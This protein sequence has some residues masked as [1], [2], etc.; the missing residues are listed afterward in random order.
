MH[1][2]TMS[3]TTLIVPV[4]ETKGYFL[5]ESLLRPF[6][7]RIGIFSIAH[8]LFYGHKWS[9]RR[10]RIGTA[11]RRDILGIR[12]RKSGSNRRRNWNGI[13]SHRSRRDR[14]QGSNFYTG[15]MELWGIF[16]RSRNLGKI[17]RTNR[18]DRRIATLGTVAQAVL[19][20]VKLNPQCSGLSL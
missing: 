18:R 17:R 15:S 20:V 5:V 9:A 16:R 7:H 14:T 13:R 19:H 11:S 10:G 6:R 8:D 3:P 1:C 2:L 4:K 12:R